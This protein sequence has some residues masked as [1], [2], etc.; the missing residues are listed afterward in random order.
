MQYQMDNKIELNNKMFES[1]R[2]FNMD[3]VLEYLNKG[4]DINATN[5]EGETVLTLIAKTNKFDYVPYNL[6]DWLKLVKDDGE[7]E[8]ILSVKKQI[9]EAGYF[10][11]GLS[12]GMLDETIMRAV[13]FSKERI[14][15]MKKLI[16]RG[17]DVNFFDKSKGGFACNAIYYAIKNTE[18]DSVEFLLNSS[19]DPKVIYFVDEQDSLLDYARL[20]LFLEENTLRNW[21]AE[22]TLIHDGKDKRM[23]ENEIVRL[24]RIV[25]I[26]ETQKN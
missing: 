3:K 24:K 6:A 17:A 8:I 7:M 26:L 10:K 21:D 9:E 19:A 5:E 25:E 2:R 15:M 22:R 18:P 13:D 11:G 23:Q 1:A 12:D 20:D 16:E 4:A 14:T